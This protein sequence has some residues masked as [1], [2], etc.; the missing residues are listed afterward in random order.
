MPILSGRA[1]PYR[2]V[3]HG[4]E[5]IIPSLDKNL[6]Y[7]EIDNIADGVFGHPENKHVEARVPIINEKEEII[8]KK[9]VLS[10]KLK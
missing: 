5:G 9:G 8:P 7:R 2:I 6:S 4:K 10:V 1:V 3:Y